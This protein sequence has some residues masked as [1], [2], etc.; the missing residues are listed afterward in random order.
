MQ[1]K[2]RNTFSPDQEGDAGNH[3]KG[4]ELYNRDQQRN[5]QNAS[6]QRGQDARWDEGNQFHTGYSHQTRS[7]FP[8]DSHQRTSNADRGGIHQQPQHYG[9]P[10]HRNYGDTRNHGTPSFQQRGHSSIERSNTHFSPYGDAH[11]TNKP[12]QDSYGQGHD[13]IHFEG[14]LSE[15]RRRDDSNEN[16]YHGAYIDSR[17]DHREPPLPENNPYNDYPG[18]RSRYKDDDY[19]YGS[20]HHTWYQEQRYTAD[21]GRVMDRDKG[22]IID[23]MGEGLREAWHD[24]SHGVSNLWHRNVEPEHRRPEQHRGEHQ[25]PTGDRHKYEYRAPQDRGLERGPRWSDETDNADDSFF[26][27]S[28]NP[29]RYY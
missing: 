10:Q 5:P 1:D 20:G 3:Q 7:H 11:L 24:V 25:R 26:Y 23:D 4:R 17:G 21:N 8:E 2:P 29:P 28:G 15:Q 19:R 9:S 18:S 14:R 16:Y 6:L 27:G 12:I 22:S 13:N